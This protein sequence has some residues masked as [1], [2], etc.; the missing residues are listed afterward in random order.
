VTITAVRDE[1][2]R[3][4]GFAKVTRDLT[5]R[6]QAQDALQDA[7]AEL[8]RANAEL[9]RFASIAA[10]DMTD[11]LRTISGFAEILLESDPPP[12]KAKQ[13]AGLILSSSTRLSRMLQG[14]LTYARAGS[15]TE[16]SA[17]VEVGPTIHAVLSDLGRSITE[18][19][20]EVTVGVP[21]GTTVLATSNDVQTVMQNLISN[22]V[23]FADADRPRVRVTAD[24][25]EEGAI[26]FTVTDNGKGIP[27]ADQKRIFR[28]FERSA[29][30]ANLNGHGLGLAICERLVV[31]HGGRIGLDSSHD[32]TSFW[33]TLPT[34]ASGTGTPSSADPDGQG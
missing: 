23:K 18:R 22:A 34:V 21:D 31:R 2:G 16:P 27:E 8:R 3:L 28:A 33:F 14:L 30:S 11:P 10:H 4:T 19:G 20:A 26:T 13:F 6:K 24:A 5:E 29:G 17:N 7:V 25:A 1:E 15:H 9:D 12:E 32:G